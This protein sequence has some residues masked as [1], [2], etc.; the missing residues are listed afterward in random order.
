MKTKLNARALLASLTMICIFGPVTPLQAEDLDFS[1]MKQRAREKIQVSNSYKEFDVILENRC[2]GKV[3]WSMCIE[4][5]NP[6]TIETLE[7]L[8]P[9]GEVE[10]EKKTRV[11]L[12]MK[13]ITDDSNSLQTFEEFYLNVEYARNSSLKAKCVASECEA[14]K[15][16]LRAALRA[17]DKAGEKAN[18]TLAIRLS[19]ECPDS[20]WGGAEQANCEARIRQGGQADLEQIALQDKELK[21]QLAAVEPER[22]QA[23]GG[24]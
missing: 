20:G 2:P 23:H 12:R 8:T 19:S 24:S 6:W 15:R 11:N 3:F 1:C 16:D 18:N 13:E 4:R 9:S 22:C 21:E 5:I 7:T 10:K 17:N 14:K